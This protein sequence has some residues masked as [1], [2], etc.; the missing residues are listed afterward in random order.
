MEPLTSTCVCGHVVSGTDNTLIFK[1]AAHDLFRHPV[2]TGW[3]IVRIVSLSA[4]AI[5]VLCIGA[6]GAS[7]VVLADRSEQWIDDY[8]ETISWPKGRKRSMK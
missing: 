7:F 3:D 4:L 8:R 2:V 5:I 6:F 1:K